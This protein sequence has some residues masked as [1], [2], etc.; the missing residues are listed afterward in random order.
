MGR[1]GDYN[2]LKLLSKMDSTSKALFHY[3]SLN[4]Q[5]QEYFPCYQMHTNILASFFLDFVEGNQ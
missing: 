5:K 3:F 1:F 4:T 2:D